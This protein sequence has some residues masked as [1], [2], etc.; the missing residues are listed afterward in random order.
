[1]HI[2]PDSR[3]A[4]I[5][6]TALPAWGL[7]ASM[8]V[9]AAFAALAMLALPDPI[10]TPTVP[11]SIAVE[12]LSEAEFAAI[13]ARPAS[14]PLAAPTPSVPEPATADPQPEPPAAP[15]AGNDTVEATQMFAADLLA[16][17]ASANLR[18]AMG[19]LEHNERLVQLC[20]IEAIAQVRA[21]WPEYDP[22]TVVAYAMALTDIRH[23][24]LV[25]DGAAFR[26]R[27]EWYELKF[28]CE[29]LADLTGVTAF[30]FS[31]GELIPH[32]LWEVYYLNAAE[33][34]ERE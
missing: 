17:P 2:A 19:T 32:E 26:S 20:D 15:R 13:A 7:S 33:S 4:P 1:M 8:L 6:P 21:A 29:A 18:R 31:V 30:S 9:H 16:E 5:R 14:A 25:A 27:R 34:D 23:G 3:V 12:V 11:R 10:A 28:R 24:A 22:D